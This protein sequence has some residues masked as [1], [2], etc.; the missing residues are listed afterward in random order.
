MAFEEVLSLDTS[1][2]I[3][4]GGTDRKTGKPNPTEIEGFFLGTRNC[5]PSKFDKNKDVSQHIFQTPQGNIGVWSKTDMARKLK[6]VTPGTMTRVTYVGEVDTG[7]GNP[8]LQYKIAV[9]KKNTIDVGNLSASAGESYESEFE[10]DDDENR[11][12]Y[13]SMPSA[14]PAVVVKGTPAERKANV[15]KYLNST[16]NK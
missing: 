3:V 1:V 9:D 12:E 6:N 16:K 11:D 8:M 5:G 15:E 7:K 13:H 10:A 4:V 2:T 14:V